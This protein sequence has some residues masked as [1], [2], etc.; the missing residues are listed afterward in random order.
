MMPPVPENKLLV[1]KTQQDS[2]VSKQWSEWELKLNHEWPVSLV[3]I[4]LDINI[5]SP[6]IWIINGYTEVYTLKTWENGYTD[7]MVL[8]FQKHDLDDQLSLKI[9][10]PFAIASPEHVLLSL[11]HLN[12]RRRQQT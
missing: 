11:V 1:N 4:T 10:F 9:W 2:W 12:A 7:W 3:L 8:I 5:N 6:N